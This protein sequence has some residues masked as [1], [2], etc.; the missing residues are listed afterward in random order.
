M[1][2][3]VYSVGYYSEVRRFKSF[4]N[5][6]KLFTEMVTDNETMRE[7][8]QAGCEQILRAIKNTGS[9]SLELGDVCLD[10]IHVE[11]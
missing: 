9:G 5:A 11:D 2:Y 10:I 6:Y 4:C 7:V 1:F 8:M 3:E